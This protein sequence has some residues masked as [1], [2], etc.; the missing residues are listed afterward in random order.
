MGWTEKAS[1]LVSAGV[2]V[3]IMLTPGWLYAERL[4][5]VEGQA[6]YRY[7]DKETPVQAKEEALALAR[8]NAVENHR[9]FIDS[10]STVKDFQLEK[11]LVEAVSVG[12]LTQIKILTQKEEGREVCLSISGMIN[13][14]QTEDLI[15]QRTKAKEIVKAA[16]SEEVSPRSAFALKLSVNK[17]NGRYEEGEEL[18]IYLQSESDGYL[19]LDYFQADGKVVH[20][21]PNL[22]RGQA[23][24]EK[25]KQYTFGG[26]MSAER[27]TID[28][29]FGD[30]LIKVFVS[31]QPIPEIFESNEL[32][33]DSGTHLQTMKM[34][35]RGVRVQANAAVS[36]RTSQKGLTPSQKP[37]LSQN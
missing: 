23:K 2:A 14:G 18:I 11:D 24:I 21:V 8:K 33:E 36:L 19:K 20:L 17:S 7:G 1:T 25:G 4:E 5:A 35:L 32:I 16:Q 30:E 10:T 13:P 12:T 26:V 15:E 3:L 37:T 29:P 31:P 34:K 9:V 6:C 22:F 27:F 28:G